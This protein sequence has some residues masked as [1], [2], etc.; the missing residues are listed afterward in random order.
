M[1]KEQCEAYVEILTILEHMERKYQEK[2]PQK[3]IDF[4]ERNSAKDYKFDIDLSIPLKEQKLKDKT[5]SLL[6]MLNLN[7]WCESDEEKQELI[8]NYSK[9]EEKYQMELRKKYN[10]DNLFKKYNKE[11]KTVDKIIENEVALI[12]YKE[13]IFKRFINKIKNILHIN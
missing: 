8:N 10:P 13:S 1:K 7:Y 6:A 4:F 9:N 2:V 12:E 5:L 11:D 3:L